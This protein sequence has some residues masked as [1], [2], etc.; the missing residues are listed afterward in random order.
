M[1]KLR[2]HRIIWLTVGILSAV[3]GILGIIG[4]PIFAL[5]VM[6]VPMGISIA[7]LAHA[8]YG[9]P[10]YFI[11]FA[12]TS[13]YER[14]LTAVIKEKISELP[15]IAQYAMVKESSIRFLLEKVIKK[16]YLEGYMI[17]EERVLKPSEL[18][19]SEDD[20]QQYKKCEFCGTKLSSTDKNCSS[21]G[22]PNNE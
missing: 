20:G 5:N 8:F 13:I 15:L 9:C 1:K 18:L 22:A 21:C 12:N 14:I 10:F 11:A 16:G 19:N 3:L 4:I 7:L 2:T 6:F 17:S